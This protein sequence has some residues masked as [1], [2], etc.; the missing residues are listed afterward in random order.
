MGPEKG[1]N[2]PDVG[3]GQSRE[4]SRFSNFWRKKLQ[5]ENFPSNILG[6]SKTCFMCLQYFVNKKIQNSKT[7]TAMISVCYWIDY[8]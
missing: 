7:D 1:D 8:T 2:T 5:E 3:E 4:N 6:G